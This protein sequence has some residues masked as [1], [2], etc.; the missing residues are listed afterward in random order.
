VGAG[1]TEVLGCQ[2][3]R[4]RCS[5]QQVGELAAGEL[6]AYVGGVRRLLEQMGVGVEGHARPRVAE[7]AADLSD[8]EA[9]VDDQVA[10]EGVAQVVEAQPLLA[11]VE[12]SVSGCAAKRTL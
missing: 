4:L 9:D 7:D 12:P 5:R 6:S 11:A 8:V 2:E 10:G 1:A 3:L